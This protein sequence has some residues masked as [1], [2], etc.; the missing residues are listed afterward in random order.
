VCSNTI[1]PGPS[2]LVRQPKVDKKLQNQNFK[3]L[4]DISIEPSQLNVIIGPNGSGK[5][6]LLQAIDFMRAFFLPSIDL[7]LE[8]QGWKY[9]DIPNLKGSSKTIKWEL[10]AELNGDSDG[11]GSGIY[12]YSIT[13]SPSDT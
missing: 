5:S 6:S 13:L 9:R 3:I 7:Y 11:R 10:V 12:E 8:R 1:Y 4:Q 2:R